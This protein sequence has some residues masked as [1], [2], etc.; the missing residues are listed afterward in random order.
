MMAGTSTGA[1]VAASL[2]LP[3]KPGIRQPRYKG[4]DIVQLYTSH[5][6]K[7][8]SRASY[9]QALFG[10]KAT[11][12]DEGRKTVF[13]KYFEDTRLSQALTD[14]IITTVNSGSSTTELFRRSDSL[15]DPSRDH[16]FTDILM[17]TTAAPTYFPPYRLNDSIFVDGGVQANNPTMIAYAEACAKHVNRDNIF[18]LSLGTGDYVP[19]PL[20]PNSERSLLFW[21]YNNSNVLKV[22]FDGPQNN[23]DCQLSNMLDSDKYHRWQLW[24][25]NPILLDDIRKETLDKLMELAHAHFEEMDAFDNKNRLGKLIERLKGQ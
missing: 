5:S 18:I 21:F 1:I 12:T 17:C 13:D 3:V 4:V 14:L 23:I 20:H 15:I 6:G 8:F 25:E 22:V 7:V 19:D 11:Y 24:L 2:S 9:L 10:L 16:K